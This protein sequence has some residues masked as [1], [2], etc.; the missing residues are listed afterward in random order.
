MAGKYN[1][2]LLHRIA[3][4]RAERLIAVTG[5]TVRGTVYGILGTALVQGNAVRD[6]VKWDYQPGGIEGVPDS[7]ARAYSIMMSEPQGPIYMVYDSA[8]QEAPLKEKIEVPNYKV[9]VP[10][11]VA[12][13]QAAID[14]A[15]AA[16][17]HAGQHPVV[18]GDAEQGET[19]DEHSGD[20][21]GLEGQRSHP[22]KVLLAAHHHGRLGIANEIFDLAQC[23]AHHRDGD[24]FRVHPAVLVPVLQL[25]LPETTLGD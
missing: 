17:A 2:V 5:A 19:G 15:A 23:V 16:D 25:A 13:E 11:R 18:D 9:K 10:S 8:M 22:A 6:F 3:G 1:Q 14:Q 7:F 4:A 24:V 21:A 20:S 12:P